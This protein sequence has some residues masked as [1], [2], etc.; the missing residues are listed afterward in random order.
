MHLTC[1]WEGVIFATNSKLPLATFVVGQ[2]CSA[3]RE[4]SVIGSASKMI[5][6]SGIFCQERSIQP[7][8]CFGVIFS[9]NEKGL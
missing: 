4:S 3:G 5:H 1:V 9:T 8:V 7:Y 6:L 2:T